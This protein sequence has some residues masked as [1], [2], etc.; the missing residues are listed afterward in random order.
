MLGRQERPDLAGVQ[1]DEEL[2]LPSRA[3]G[4]P[5][6]IFKRESCDQI[7]ILESWFSLLST[8]GWTKYK[9]GRHGAEMQVSGEACSLPAGWGMKTGP[10]WQNEEAQG[11]W[12][13]S[14]SSIY[15]FRPR[16]ANGNILSG[17]FYLIWGPR[18]WLRSHHHEMSSWVELNAFQWITH[19]R[20]VINDLIH[21]ALGSHCS[22]E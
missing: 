10:I 22:T 21:C 20:V 7:C 11:T 14:H 16:G 5:W 8:E 6:S 18:D 1:L 19:T 2:D 12:S 9:I 3:M 15:H 13:I 17:S 4:R